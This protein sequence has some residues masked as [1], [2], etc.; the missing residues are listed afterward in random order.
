MEI[1]FVYKTSTEPCGFVSVYLDSQ[2]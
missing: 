1:I 2:P